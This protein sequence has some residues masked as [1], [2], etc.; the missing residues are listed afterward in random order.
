MVIR[1]FYAI[2]LYIRN[3]SDKRK[4]GTSTLPFEIAQD[5]PSLPIPSY[6]GINSSER[7]TLFS[8]QGAN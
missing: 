7:L 4:V 1:P 8:V 5:E 6:E 3:F 2:W